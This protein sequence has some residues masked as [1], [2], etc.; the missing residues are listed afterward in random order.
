MRKHLVA[1]LKFLGFLSIGILLL[2]LVFRKVPLQDVMY[3]FRHANY[4]W[5][6]LSVVIGVIS[7]LARAARW[8][9]LI[10][11]MGY[12]TK[13]SSTF[14]AVMTG[15]FV[16]AAVPRLG[17][18]TR[19]GVL[20][21]KDKI[22][23]NNLFGTVVAERAFDMLMLLLIMFLV[24]IFQLE[25]L[26][27]FVNDQVVS[28]LYIKFHDS[29]G[30]ILLVV[31]V[32]IFM[33]VASV[34]MFRLYW[35]KIK[36]KGFALKIN[37]FIVGFMNGLKTIQRLNQKFAFIFWTILIWLGYG[38][39]TYVVFKALTATSGLDFA[40]GFTVMAIASMGMIAPVPGGIGAYHFFATLVMFELYG[41][42]KPA[43]ASWATIAHASQGILILSV[44]AV[45]YL[46]II[47]QIR[48]KNHG[49]SQ[50]HRIQNQG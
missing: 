20:S 8:N 7:H 43:A 35:P 27:D 15:Y 37:D 10:S 48:K 4:W 2:W 49:I 17:E 47:L 32:L 44:G 39:M 46:M 41:I 30:Y 16:N 13:L 29:A 26:G 3:Q 45:S 5:V 36:H 31:L 22:P 33:L 1:I 42:P 14:Y 50:S 18:L 25:L 19:C 40:D 38:T 24:V 9:I 21:R 28:P 23:L 6:L 11:S 34:L 12:P